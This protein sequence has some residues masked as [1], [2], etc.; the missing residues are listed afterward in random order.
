[1]SSLR[2][3]CP[4]DWLA[5][6]WYF[7]TVLRSVAQVVLELMILLFQVLGAGFTGVPS[8]S[9][10]LWC[11]SREAIVPAGYREGLPREEGQGMKCQLGQCDRFQPAQADWRP[12]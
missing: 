12:L 1:M 4:L 5:C 6:V 8:L 7:E 10:L 3:F 9:S 2:G 11:F